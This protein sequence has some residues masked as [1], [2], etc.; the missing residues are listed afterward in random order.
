[1]AVIHLYVRGCAWFLSAHKKNGKPELKIFFCAGGDMFD[2]ELYGADKD[3]PQGSIDG[4]YIEVLE[5]R[6]ELVV[7]AAGSCCC[8]CCC[9]AGETE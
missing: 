4:L 6:V 5:R 7:A 2:F 3:R 1:M 9:N 8:C